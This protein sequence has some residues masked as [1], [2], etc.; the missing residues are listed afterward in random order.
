MGLA[1]NL[2]TSKKESL[3]KAT[4]AIPQFRIAKKRVLHLESITK[5]SD[6]LIHSLYE[7]A[8]SLLGKDIGDVTLRLMICK[9]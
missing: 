1:N 4:L 7:Y 2:R 3:K 5:I 8:V 6:G 9:T